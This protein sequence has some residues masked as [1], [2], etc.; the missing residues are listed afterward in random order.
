[1]VNGEGRL[2]SKHDADI[3]NTLMPSAKEKK[4]LQYIV[5][6]ATP[7]E[8]EAISKAE[9]GRLDHALNLLNEAIS[10]YPQ[11]P[12]VW[13]NRAQINRLLSQDEAAIRDL[14]K[15]KELLKEYIDPYTELRV[16]EQLGWLMFKKGKSEEAQEYFRVAADLGSEEA[17]RMQVRCNP[18]A[19]LCNAMF[20]EA[21]S[22]NVYFCKP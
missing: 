1:M 6:E 7:T 22:Q 13:N 5:T 20:R 16:N 17:K 8:V 12:S 14:L 2:L 9:A 3:L 18:Y 19:E 21:M 4:V 11:V 10:K 15:A